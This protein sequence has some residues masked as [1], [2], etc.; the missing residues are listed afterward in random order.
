MKRFD[1]LLSNKPNVTANTYTQSHCSRLWLISS[2]GDL[3]SESVL[4]D[5]FVDVEKI[6]ESI[7]SN[8]PCSKKRVAKE[9]HF[10]KLRISETALCNN[11][12]QQESRN[13]TK[14][15]CQ[16][17]ESNGTVLLKTLWNLLNKMI[18]VETL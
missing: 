4:S 1:C 17:I 15:S 3:R 5:V 8:S 2:L 9:D 14:C 6:D 13:D 12:E 11:S 18:V 7:E 16:G 10:V